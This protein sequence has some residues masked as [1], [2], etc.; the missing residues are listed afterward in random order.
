M[1]DRVNITGQFASAPAIDPFL[2]LEAEIDR[3]RRTRNA[4]ILAHFYQDS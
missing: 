1:D 3:L 4:V 2:D